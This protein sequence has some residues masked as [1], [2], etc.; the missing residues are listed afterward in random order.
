MNEERSPNDSQCR[1]LTHG[2]EKK[3]ERKKEKNSRQGNERLRRSI[4]T[5]VGY[6]RV[7]LADEAKAEANPRPIITNFMLVYIT[8]LLSSRD[9]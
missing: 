3:K 6:G 1:I 4:L 7:L 2:V 5:C 9:L 8:E